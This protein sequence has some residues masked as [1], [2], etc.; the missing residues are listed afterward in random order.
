MNPIFNNIFKRPVHDSWSQFYMTELTPDDVVREYKSILA[1]GRRV[2]GVALVPSPRSRVVV[3]DLDKLEGL[4]ANLVALRLAGK[5][6]VAVTPRGGL[7]LAVR[8]PEG[9]QLPHRFTVT[10]YGDVI[11]EGGGTFK[12][13]WTFPPAAACI[14]TDSS[15]KCIEIRPY[16]YVLPDGRS[17]KYPWQLPWR[18]PPVMP[19]EE[20]VDILSLMLQADV[21]V[22][23]TSGPGEL[24]VGVTNDAIPPLPCW[25]TLEEFKE[26]LEISG[27]PPLPSCVA[28][29]LGYTSEYGIMEYTGEKVPHGMRFVLGAAAVMFLAA[30]IASATA[31][32][33]I[34]TVGANLED[35]PSDEGEPLD[36][37]LSRLLLKAGRDRVIPRYSGLGSIQVP[38]DLCSTCEYK[39]QCTGGYYTEGPPE[40]PK[41]RSPWLAFIPRYY[42]IWRGPFRKM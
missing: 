18:A 37:K 35:F 6:V 19:W 38:V 29:A 27:H 39:L 14:K 28:R 26:W 1:R 9:E 16:Y 20:L 8:I 4:D 25:R 41:R 40:D 30:C 7:R 22:E 5:M 17:A 21:S 15:G 33:L 32:E 12:H 23:T 11:G 2:S 24:K 36:T 3:V 10:R 13:P 34:E 31:E 42:Y